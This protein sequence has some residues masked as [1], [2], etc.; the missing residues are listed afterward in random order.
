MMILDIE[1]LVS[2]AGVAWMTQYLK[3]FDLTIEEMKSTVDHVQST[4]QVCPSKRYL[5]EI[6]VELRVLVTRL[7]GR[8]DVQTIQT[9]LVDAKVSFL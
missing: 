7:D 5:S 2:L 1:T 3:E 4:L 6:L 9:Y 8:E